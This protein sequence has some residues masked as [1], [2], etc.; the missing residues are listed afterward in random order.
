[1]FF[2]CYIAKKYQA[3]VLKD[4]NL[5]NIYLVVLKTYSFIKNSLNDGNS[6]LVYIGEYYLI[7]KIRK[8]PNQN[9]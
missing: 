9:S 6:L 2:L 3:S 5:I 8:R 1:M 4:K 7:C